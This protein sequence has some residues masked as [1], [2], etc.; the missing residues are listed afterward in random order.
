MAP[1]SGELLA[2]LQIQSQLTKPVRQS[3]LFD[4][5]TSVLYEN[6]EDQLSD[7]AD[8]FIAAPVFQGQ[9]V[10]LVEDN[11]VNQLVASEMLT[12]L[13]LDVTVA[14]NGQEAVEH[15][16]HAAYDLILMDCQMPVMDGFAATRVIR[17]RE[18][19]LDRNRTPIVAVTANALQGDREK[20]IAAGM[21]DYLSKPFTNKALQAVLH[22]YFSNDDGDAVSEIDDP[23]ALIAG[24][25][26]V[27]VKS[28]IDPNMLRQLASLEASSGKKIVARILE[29][30]LKSAYELKET[31][32]EAL[33]AEDW[34][35][36]TQAAHT[37]KS[38][39]A[40]VGA[41]GLS[42]LCKNLEMLARDGEVC[43]PADHAIRIER[44]YERVV[45][46][47]LQELKQM[48]ESAA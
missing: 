12:A 26:E 1:A 29:V 24:S 20:C 25:G 3:D 11:E 41:T 4:A 13:G 34:R 44:E 35:C 30:F 6:Y 37:L 38:S 43:S 42:V 21:N 32:C 18:A 5:L 40:N 36:V 31:L 23:A 28:V 14:T 27:V 46:E 45:A 33:R 8:E 15:Y 10:L 39:S 48:K 7:D 47:L 17:E 16:E 2:T 9:Q 22:I 19:A